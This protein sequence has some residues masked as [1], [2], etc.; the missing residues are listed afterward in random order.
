[1]T[2]DGEGVSERTDVDVLFG[3]GTGISKT[4]GN[5]WYHQLV[6][7]HRR[8]YIEAPRRKKLLVAK[9]V[10]NTIQKEGGRFLRMT[11]V[12][13]PN[14]YVVVS[15][16]RA[17]EKTQQALREQVRCR[18]SRLMPS[19]EQSE[20]KTKSTSA[21]S[22]P[23]TSNSKSNSAIKASKVQTKPSKPAKRSAKI[24]SPFHENWEDSPQRSPIFA[25]SDTF[26]V[27]KDESD[28]KTLRPEW[29]PYT[30]ASAYSG[31]DHWNDMYRQ[32]RGYY[33][34]FGHSGVPPNWSGHSELADW[35]A[36]QRQV[37]R[38]ITSAYRPA[39]SRDKSRWKQLQQ[40]DFVLNYDEWHWSAKFNELMESLKGSKYCNQDY[41]A[42]SLRIWVE[43]Q[44]QNRNGSHPTSQDRTQK[45]RH[46]GVL[47]E[48]TAKDDWLY[49]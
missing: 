8:K 26:S 3:R 44:Q 25:A 17:L 10:M 47:K 41:I 35:V 16:N 1:M 13:G 20:P 45:L 21:R 37:Y 24:V 7:E 12:A 34:T 33:E 5:I 46:I 39:T 29:I 11:D 15:A 30:P 42:P 31:D 2:D 14:E 38:E 23:N 32:L 49:I 36:I 22:S 9:Q 4:P 43:E 40:L 27:E 28:E 18:P 6:E 48:T 19:T